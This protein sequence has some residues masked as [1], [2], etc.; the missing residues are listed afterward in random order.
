MCF[1]IYTNDILGKKS[2]LV[3]TWFLA[4]YVVGVYWKTHILT[5]YNSAFL[6]RPKILFTE[7]QAQT[8]FIF[9]LKSV[10][11]IEEVLLFC[12]SRKFAVGYAG[13]W[14]QNCTS[15]SCRRCLEYQKC[16]RRKSERRTRPSPRISSIQVQLCSNIVHWS[17]N[18]WNGSTILLTKTDI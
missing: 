4:K 5:K 9:W 12:S 14:G 15:K 18:T 8:N 17:S 6:D 13:R 3:K 1:P 7:I 16:W 2:N 10:H 11:S